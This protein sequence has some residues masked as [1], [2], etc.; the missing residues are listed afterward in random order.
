M[1]R[2]LENAVSCVPNVASVA[3]LQRRALAC[4]ARSGACA[5]SLRRHGKLCFRPAPS[6]RTPLRA[7]HAVYR[8]TESTQAAE[9]GGCA[10]LRDALASQLGRS[11]WRRANPLFVAAAAAEHGAREAGA[12]PV[13]SCFSY[14]EQASVRLV[15]M[16]RATRRAG[17]G[18]REGVARDRLALPTCRPVILWIHF[19]RHAR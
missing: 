14:A 4:S 19:T 7:A 13:S 5:P 15:R 1:T 6:L 8:H 2:T 9:G 10:C 11:T 3:K 12:R 17:R 18:G 16:P